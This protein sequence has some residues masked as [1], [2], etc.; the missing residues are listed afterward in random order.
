MSTSRS[1]TGEPV[2]GRPARRV[3]HGGVLAI[4]AFVAGCD[5]HAGGPTAPPNVGVL[6]LVDGRPVT[7][8]DFR[9]S[10]GSRP[11]VA[12]SPQV[13]QQMLERLIERSAWAGAARKA[14]LERDPEVAAEVERMLIARL[15]ST[16]LQ[17]RF[18][19][20]G[21]P[22]ADVTAE[23]ERG[24]ATR[25]HRPG[26]VRVAVLWFDTHGQA[27]LV[28]RYRPRLE[29]IR[30]QVAKAGAAMP[31]TNGF[32][33]LALANSEHR[34]SRYR[35]G[36]TGWMTVSAGADA[37]TTEVQR[38]AATLKEPGDL[39]EV[40]ATAA[41]LF[42]VRLTAR[43]PGGDQPL[44]AVREEIRLALL[45]ER[46]RQVEE[47]FQQEILNAAHVERPPDAAARLAALGLPVR[48]NAALSRVQTGGAPAVTPHPS[49][50]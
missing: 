34:V 31:A 15:R 49:V 11:A 37:W 8:A 28:E 14:G 43:Q 35:G 2:P 4:L 21:V 16:R 7:E 36:D 22:E 10:W 1:H 5:R 45:A 32:G 19:R 20:I 27:P 33:T 40:S 41:G 38:L 6:A 24:R 23:Y 13:R 46:R 3:W 9:A 25:Y 39:S 29:A 48:T 30:S 47:Q 50:P 12:D 17:E 26:Q 42:L 44:A 18:D